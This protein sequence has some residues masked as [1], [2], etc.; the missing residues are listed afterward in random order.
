MKRLKS[1][2]FILVILLGVEGSAQKLD[3]TAEGA[4]GVYISP[5]EN[6]R[7]FHIRTRDDVWITRDSSL[8]G[9]ISVTMGDETEQFFV[10]GGVLSLSQSEMGM[11]TWEV[12]SVLAAIC[13][14][15]GT[16][17]VVGGQV[18][19]VPSWLFGDMERSLGQR[20]RLIRQKN[21][22]FA[23]ILVALP[24]GFMGFDPKD[25]N[26]FTFYNA[27]GQS[28][29]VADGKKLGVARVVTERRR[30]FELRHIALEN[31]G[32][33]SPDEIKALTSD[34]EAIGY[35]LGITRFVAFEY[36]TFSG[37][38]HVG[39]SGGIT[40]L[41]IKGDLPRFYGA[42]GQQINS[43]ETTDGANYALKQ[44][45]RISMA[46]IDGNITATLLREATSVAM[47]E[48]GVFINGIV[49]IDAGAPAL[50]DQDSVYGGL[51]VEGTVT[52]SGT[53]QIRDN[54][55]VAQGS[56]TTI[57]FVSAES[58]YAGYKASV[59]G[60]RVHFTNTGIKVLNVGGRI[61]RSSGNF[62]MAWTGA[63]VELGVKTEHV[64]LSV[65]D[66]GNEERGLSERDGVLT[67][68]NMAPEEVQSLQNMYN[69]YKVRMGGGELS[70]VNVFHGLTGIL[71]GVL[72][73]TAVD[74]S[75][76]KL[77]AADYIK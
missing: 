31:T 15:S 30:K 5:K 73:F 61:E 4:D 40:T 6:G 10:R 26:R 32:S 7:V 48:T 57:T 39:A 66:G 1:V 59:A 52:I 19:P 16:A 43:F 23:G 72:V 63:A 74:G 17:L 62:R 56:G 27:Q 13:G 64:M 38:A 76:V 60:T 35:S 29:A 24:C 47:T 25:Q 51:W 53:V 58:S 28:I 8:D 50:L 77:R 65:S 46:G 9:T 21:R 68:I 37:F 71:T 69:D 42:D 12:R 18:W 14:A 70:E 67:G 3:I 22:R 75:H 44:D 11:F 41:L 54:R 45:L 20:M 36:N 55:L 2:I 33:A 49:M 34:L